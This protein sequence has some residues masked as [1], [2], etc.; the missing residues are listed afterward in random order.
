MQ[1]GGTKSACARPCA[2]QILLAV[3]ERAAMPPLGGEFCVQS[4]P[5]FVLL[6]FNA[7][8]LITF[9]RKMLLA[10]A[11]STF[12][13]NDCKRSALA[14]PLFWH[15]TGP[16][17]SNFYHFWSLSSLRCSFGSLFVRSMPTSKTACGPSLVHFSPPRPRLQ[18]QLYAS[19]LQFCEFRVLSAIFAVSLMLHTHV[20]C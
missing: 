4:V 18:K 7:P 1:F 10:A 9:F 3:A 17:K 13:Q 12:L 14:N 8:F 16:D 2:V 15:P 6:L 20:S 5:P 11:G 19:H